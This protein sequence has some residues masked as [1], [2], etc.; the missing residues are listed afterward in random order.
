MAFKDLSEFLEETFAIRHHERIVEGM[1]WQLGAKKANRREEYL[2]EK[3]GRTER[4]KPGF[5]PWQTPEGRNAK[6]RERQ[7]ARRDAARGD[8]PRQSWRLTPA[9][10]EWART[11]GLPA[12]AVAAQLGVTDKAIYLL[13]RKS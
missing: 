7:R 4:L 11:C 6:R 3:N 8:R 10:K 5:A 13:R 12:T 9:Q 1:L 2:F